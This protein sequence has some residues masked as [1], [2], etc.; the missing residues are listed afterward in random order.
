MMKLSVI[1]PAYNHLGDV[2]KCVQAVRM[3]THPQFVELLVQDDASPEYNGP[4]LLGPMCQRNAENLGFAGNCNAGAARATGD[5]LM[6][7]NQDAWPIAPGWDKRLLDFFALEPRAGIAG[8]T[9]LFP[10]GRIQSVGGQFDSAGQ[11]FHEALG[12]AN[13][14]WEPISRPRE[15]KWITGAA[16]AVRRETWEQLGG[17]DT[18]Y[19]RGYFEDVDLCMRAR[20]AGWTVWHRPNVRMYHAAGG[21]GGS[22]YFAQNARLFKA[23]WVDTKMIKPDVPYLAV[24]YWA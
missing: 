11:P 6:F 24:R 3:T 18:A 14:D 12:Y 2:L 10:D 4:E 20:Q 21:T 17:F 1:I 9:L 23:R 15:V 13:P 22:A 5:V 16:L 8:P 7:L 19:V